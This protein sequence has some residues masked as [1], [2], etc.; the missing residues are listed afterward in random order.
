MPKVNPK[1]IQQWLAVGDALMGAPVASV[2]FSAIAAYL[3]KAGLT[4][5]Q[6]AGMKARYLDAEQREARARKRAGQV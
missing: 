6:I 4:P 5:E 1:K 3:P 2:V